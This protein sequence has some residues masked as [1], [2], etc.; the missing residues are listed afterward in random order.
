MPGLSELAAAIAPAIRDVDLLGECASGTLGIL[1]LEVDAGE[2]HLVTR[3]IADAIR[4]VEFSAPL[5]FTIG[6]AVCPTDGSDMS[7]LVEHAASHPVMG[8]RDSPRADPTASFT[9]SSGTRRDPLSV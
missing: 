6:A 4:S 7:S 5:T 8:M 2:A 9:A 3:R 1:C